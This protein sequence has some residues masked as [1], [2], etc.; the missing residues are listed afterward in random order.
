MSETLA[1]VNESLDSRSVPSGVS[2]DSGKP[3][4]CIRPHDN[5]RLR[6]LGCALVLAKALERLG[7]VSPLESYVGTCEG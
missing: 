1:I 2:H 4:Y 7:T 3:G 6:V 5:G